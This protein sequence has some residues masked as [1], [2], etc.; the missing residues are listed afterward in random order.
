[1]LPFANHKFC[2]I[3]KSKFAIL[4]RACHCRN[5]GVCV[6]KDCVVPWPA[7]M[8][9]DTYNIK[10]EHFVHA[11][12]SCNWLSNSFR[13]A[14][15][16]GNHDRAVALHSTGNL[17]LHSPFANVKGELFYP[18]HCAV[19]GGSLGLLKFLVDDNCCPI[20]SV[21]VAGSGKDSASKY[22]P[23]VTSKGRSLL[24]IALENENL[25]ILRYLVAE[26]GIMLS[27]ERDVTQDLLCRNLEKLLRHVPED[28]VTGNPSLHFATPHTLTRTESEDGSQHPIMGGNVAGLES[29]ASPADSKPSAEIHSDDDPLLSVSLNDEARD[30]GAI[31]MRELY[32]R[33]LEN[34][35]FEQLA[36]DEAVAHEECKCSVMY[37]TRVLA[38]WTVC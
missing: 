13:L 34:G 12:L 22:T 31:T 28:S 6:C 36:I 3:C 10:K 24:G 2:H 23:I 17:N 9:P 29:F 19:L 33:G 35:E 11:C 25:Q 30:L 1:M 14:L 8:I 20:K 15:L 16:E 18:V 26:K 38:N 37:G 7:K 5:C 32:Q 4:R 21:R 27:G